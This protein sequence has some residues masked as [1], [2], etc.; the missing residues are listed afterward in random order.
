M[1][2]LD[3]IRERAALELTTDDIRRFTIADIAQLRVDIKRLLRL[4]D[5]QIEARED[6]D[7]TVEEGAELMRR[8]RGEG[9]D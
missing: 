7:L 2:N 1:T 4:I 8:M 9:T 6:D 5:R 3:Q